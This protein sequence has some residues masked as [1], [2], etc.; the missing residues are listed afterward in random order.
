MPGLAKLSRAAA[1]LGW[2]PAL[3][4]LERCSDQVQTGWE[5]KVRENLSVTDV[6]AHQFWTVKPAKSQSTVPLQG[7]LRFLRE[8]S[9]RGAILWHHDGSLFVTQPLSRLR[10]RS[11]SSLIPALEARKKGW[12]VKCKGFRREGKSGRWRWVARLSWM[13]GE[14]FEV[15]VHGALAGPR[16]GRLAALRKAVSSLR[17]IG[18]RP[19]PHAT[20]WNRGP[21]GIVY[22]ARS[23]ISFAAAIALARRVTNWMPPGHDLP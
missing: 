3:L 5:F 18:L 17:R 16:D 13:E 1:G 23:R 19:M 2:I 14:G 12:R 4:D 9:P 10:G 22:L 8:R 11:W 21:A 7:A 20:I 15:T 6:G